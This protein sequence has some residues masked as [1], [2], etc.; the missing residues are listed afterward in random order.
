[1]TDVHSKDG[2][3]RNMRAIHSKNTKPELAV[4]RLLHRAGLR[5]RLHRK[6]LPGC[7]DIILP[8]YRTVIFVHG[9]FWHGHECPLF[10]LPQTRSEFWVQKIGATR[11]RD[12]RD[13][14]LLLVAGWRI[15]NVW[16][17]AI[18]G[19]RRHTEECLSQSII[20]WIL[21]NQKTGHL[22]FADPEQWTATPATKI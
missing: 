8:K 22:G 12:R 6:D 18:K 19:S 3:S 4:R 1:M 11:E 10:K 14:D 17:C 2:R 21:S 15:L 5:F 20:G 7:P 9:C 13:T 16:E